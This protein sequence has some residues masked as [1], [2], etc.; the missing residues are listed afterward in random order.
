[1]I[2]WYFNIGLQ[3]YL[4]GQRTFKNLLRHYQG[5]CKN[6]RRFVVIAISREDTDDDND[7]D[8]NAEQEV[9]DPREPHQV[10]LP[11]QPA[12]RVSAVPLG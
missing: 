1:M 7:D 10:L 9:E 8:D 11:P 5:Q 2:F 12:H 6:S 3:I 4:K